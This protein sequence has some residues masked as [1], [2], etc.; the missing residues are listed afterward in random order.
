MC[1]EITGA[2]AIILE[3]PFSASVDQFWDEIIARYT[4]LE[5]YRRHSRIAVNMEYVSGPTLLREG[6]EVCI[7]PPVSGG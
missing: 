6:D 3:L 7:I 4:G 5:K 1:R 2:D